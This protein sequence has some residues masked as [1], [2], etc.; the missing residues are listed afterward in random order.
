MKPALAFAALAA[1]LL[2][3]ALAF[4]FKGQAVP[5]LASSAPERYTGTEIENRAAPAFQLADPTGRPVALQDFQGKLVVLTFLDPHCRDTCPITAF[6]LRA[7]HQSLGPRAEEVVYLGVN[8][9]TA[10]GRPEDLDAFT[11]SFAL[12]T[13][14]SWHFL[15]GSPEQLQA[16]W[17]SYGVAAVRG[18]GDRLDH[19]SGVFLIDR[20]GMLRLYI[21]APLG[22]ENAPRLSDA[23]LERMQALF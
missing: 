22:L 13:L 7:L 16:V 1:A 5:T 6:E 4:Y 15:N 11:S 23:L 2:L 21:S 18:A 8:T 17:A 12:D 9:N 10:A 14:P 20:S 3:G 19:T